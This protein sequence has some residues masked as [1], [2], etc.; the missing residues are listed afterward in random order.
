MAVVVVVYNYSN[1][2]GIFTNSWCIKNPDKCV[3]EEYS[4]VIMD[5]PMPQEIFEICLNN[6]NIDLSNCIGTQI[7]KYKKIIGVPCDKFRKKTQAEI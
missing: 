2:F 3:C 5:S 6:S 1:G 7:N 4:E